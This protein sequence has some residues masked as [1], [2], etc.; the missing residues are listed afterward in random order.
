MDDRWRQEIHEQLDRALAE[1]GHD[2]IA[3]I[4]VMVEYVTVTEG[5]ERRELVV[6]ASLGPDPRLSRQA[7]AAVHALAP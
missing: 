5:F 1:L 2:A 6:R 3:G 4:V 7:L